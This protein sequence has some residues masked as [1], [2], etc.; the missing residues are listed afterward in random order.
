MKKCDNFIKFHIPIDSSSYTN[1]LSCMVNEFSIRLSI[2]SD[3]TYGKGSP[4]LKI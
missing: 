2:K 4:L 1:E 3:G